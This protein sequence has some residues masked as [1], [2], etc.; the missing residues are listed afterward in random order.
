M[1]GVVA[2][3]AR[4]S[5]EQQVLAA[6]EQQ[7]VTAALKLERLLAT[8]ELEP[9]DLGRRAVVQAYSQQLLVRGDVDDAVR[10]QHR[11]VAAPVPRRAAHCLAR[12]RRFLALEAIRA[13]QPG[14]GSGVH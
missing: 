1:I 13:P 14:A 7:P 3:G 8:F 11:R 4:R 9:R 5:E 10:A 2:L 12:G 6:Y